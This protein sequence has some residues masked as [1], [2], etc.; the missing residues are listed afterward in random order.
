MAHR[1]SVFSDWINGK[2]TDEDGS[3]V[4]L[5]FEVEEE[6]KSNMAFYTC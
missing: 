2:V 3:T 4:R 6:R 5:D 1:I